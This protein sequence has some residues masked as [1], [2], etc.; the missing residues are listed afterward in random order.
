VQIVW[1]TALFSSICLEGLGRRYLPQVPAVA[2]YFLKDIILIIGYVRFRPPPPVRRAARYLF[3]GFEVVTLVAIAWTVLEILNPEQE[4]FPLALLGLRA[5]WLWWLAPFVIAGVLQNSEHRKRAIYVL[6]AMALGV[7]VLAAVQFASP[8]NST[9]NLY[10]V[11]DG[12]EVYA[13]DMATVATTG[14]AR[15]SSTFTFLSGFVAFTLLVPAL[16]LSLGL[17][18]EERR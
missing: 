11:T 17:E 6:L 3:R 12:Q 5:Y 18:A 2:F 9:V 15:V 14:R 7:A 1:F 10:A 8:A 4:S 16:L 13:A